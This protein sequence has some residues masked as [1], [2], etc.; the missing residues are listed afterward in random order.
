MSEL[1][2]TIAPPAQRRHPDEFPADAAPTPSPDGYAPSMWAA[3]ASRWLRRDDRAVLSLWVLTRVSVFLLVGAGAWLVGA[4]PAAHHPVPYLDRWN[5]WDTEHY[6]T[7][8]HWGY[9]GDPG[10]PPQVP[11]GAFFPGFP[12]ALWILHGLFGLNFVAA[13]LLISFIAGAVAVVALGR[14]AAL[15]ASPEAPGGELAERAVLLFLLAPPAVFLAA[16]YTESLFLAFALTAWLAAKRGN[17]LAAGLL[18]AG[19][20][21]VRISGAFLAAALVVEF[22]TA[23]DGRRRWTTAPALALPFAPLVGFAAFL[24][25]RSGDWLGWQHAEEKG[26]GRD[27][28][29][30]W[31]GLSRA[32]NGMTGRELRTDFAWMY[33]LE[34][35]ASTA[36]IVLTVWLM[37]RRRWSEA[38]Y[39]GLSVVALLCCPVWQ[40]VARYSLTWWPLW[41][42][43]A[44]WSLRRPAVY[45]GLVVVFAPLLVTSTVAFSTY[46]WAG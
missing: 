39:V 29:W 41:V 9:G 11:L 44:A 28:A 13:G 27:R 43:L 10:H 1:R 17:W 15:E 8:A 40:S 45:T 32:V 2:S 16:A 46:R 14:I 26:W 7:I 4:D 20:S 23:G 22:L 36:G 34:L 37:R 5:V 6:V 31:E 12:M 30:P 19:A 18:G 3:L 24:H 33:V 25:H 42:A 35:I 38:T 21:T